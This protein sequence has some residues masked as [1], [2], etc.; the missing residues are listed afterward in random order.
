MIRDLRK[1][2]C[3]VITTGLKRKVFVQA[4]LLK[5]DITPTFING[6]V[7][8]PPIIGTALSHLK[9]LYG[10]GGETPFL[11]LEDD[12]AVTDDF[13]PI[14]EFPIT[15][16][17]V[18]LGVSTWGFDPAVSPTGIANGVRV[19]RR[20]DG[21]LQPENMLSAH[22]ILYTSPNGTLKFMEAI[23]EKLVAGT[24]FDI[25]FAEKQ[26]VLTALTPDNPFFYQAAEVGGAE[27][28]TR[29]SL[30]GFIHGLALDGESSQG[31]NSTPV[32]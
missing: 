5:V 8:A 26:A 17:V 11:I 25:G 31:S 29:Q 3:F 23:V 18:Y 12:C 13:R 7:A 10:S 1:I 9:A 32:T 4:Q 19:R 15:P 14:L 24:A 27:L 20:K 28:A 2:P 21:W 30:V 6:I 16:D 22:A